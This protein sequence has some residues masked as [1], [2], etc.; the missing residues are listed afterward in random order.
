MK[1]IVL[2]SVLCLALA[3]GP[4]PSDPEF[5]ISYPGGVPRVEISGDWRHSHYSVW[6]APAAAGPFER[7]SDSDVLC[8]GPCYADDSDVVPGATYFYRFDVVPPADAPRSFGPYAAVISR[9]IRSLSASLNPNPGRGRTRLTLFSAARLGSVAHADASIFDLQGRRV[10][11]VFRGPLS[12]GRTSL[13]WD[14]R[15]LDGRE[16]RGGIYLL[17]LATADGRSYVTRI[18]RSR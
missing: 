5:R 10:A 11:T 2:A 6:R 18:V 14:G 7:I 8:V 13:D 1:R 3:A 17:R 9:D 16:I 12:A 15:G 4:A